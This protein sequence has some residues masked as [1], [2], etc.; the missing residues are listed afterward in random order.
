MS[1]Q[2]RIRNRVE[3]AQAYQWRN[4]AATSAERPIVIGGSPRSGT[5]LLRRMLDA[6]PRIANGPES[7]LFLPGKPNLALL[8]HGY[9]IRAAVIREWLDES[10]SQTAFIETFFRAY[11]ERAGKPRWSEKTPLN[12]WHMDWIWRHFP[13]ARFVHVLRDGRDVVCSLR[14]HGERRLIDGVMV[15]VAPRPEPMQRTAGRWVNHTGKALRF[16]GDPRYVELRYEDLVAD[17]TAV[18]GRLLAAVGETFEPAMIARWTDAEAA[19]RNG[20]ELDA[21]GGIVESSVG[22]WR[23]DLTPEDVDVVKR[24]A[25]ARL[26]E[27]GYAHDD[28]W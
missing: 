22:R 23:R 25:G 3:R 8:E 16:R 12:A 14:T 15:E 21:R 1:L 27:L 17:P 11:G 19:I 24:V 20:Q 26:R 9:G 2:T 13:D 10:P 28:A 4:R 18:L 5:T 7:A 6:H